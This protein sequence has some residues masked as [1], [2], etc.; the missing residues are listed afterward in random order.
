MKKTFVMLAAMAAVVSTVVADEIQWGSGDIYSSAGSST[1]L[2]SGT[3]QLMRPG[4]DNVP[5]LM[6]DVGYDD[7]PIVG[8]NT[9]M[10]AGW[11]AL[12]LDPVAFGI[13]DGEL[14][15][16]RVYNAGN[17]EY[18]NVGDPAAAVAVVD[19]TLP[20][21]PWGYNAGSTRTDG[22]DWQPVPEPATMAL[23]GLGALTLGY[24][25]LR[26]S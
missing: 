20:S 14:I 26:K 13:A 25:K 21:I 2:T 7:T 16:S 6:S 23:L 19:S 5:S 17:T 24:R 22:T 1:V 3:A 10:N 15:Y 12:T 4:A 18:V 8:V 9:P 11:F